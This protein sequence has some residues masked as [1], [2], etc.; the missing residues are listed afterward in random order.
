MP[1]TNLRSF[2][3]K[4]SKIQADLEREQ[5]P[6]ERRLIAVPREYDKFCSS[7]TMRSGGKLLRFNPYK[8]QLLL[9]KLISLFNN[10]TVI[11]TRQLGTTQA[12]IAMF[13][14]EAAHNPAYAASCFMRNDD[15]AKA[16]NSRV[17]T[18]AKE[19]RIGTEVEQDKLIR[20]INGAEI[21]THNSSQ[22]GNRSAD[23]LCAILLDEAAFQPNASTIYSASVAS[24]IL[25]GDDA[26]ILVVSTPS[27]KSGWYWERLS[28]DNG[29]RDIEEICKQVA[30]GE[31]YT[32]DLPGFYWFADE[33]GGCK[34][35]IHW[36][37]HPVYSLMPDFVERQAKRLKMDI[38]DAQREFN[39]IFEDRA[40]E[41]FT[42]EAITAAENSDLEPRSGL[43]GCAIGLYISGTHTS[44]VALVDNVVVNAVSIRN[45]SANTA[46]NAVSEVA[47][48]YGISSIVLKNSNGGEEIADR[49]RT[50]HRGARVFDITNS[51][52]ANTIASLSLLLD[53]GRLTIPK[54]KNPIRDIPIAL[55]LRDF[56]RQGDKLGA[57]DPNRRD[58]C[59]WALAFSVK[60]SENVP[61][62]LPVGSRV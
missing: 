13:L 45:P 48:R 9:V 38:A 50:A 29:D 55:H 25:T 7:I 56:R 60:A 36:L 41:V 14:C 31:L 11:K 37:C 53:E 20:L 18:L 52:M 57:I 8:Y 4:L 23:S 47:G 33:A 39:L 42:A 61:R 17:R 51:D 62:R 24:T 34:V 49:L 26:K 16:I 19:A 32:D 10:V 28:S 40:I 30:A 12:L 58:D 35:V 46:I 44:A 59:A 22:Q 27:A 5:S 6:A 15:D 1:V 54:Y 21:R 43:N 2:N 3:A